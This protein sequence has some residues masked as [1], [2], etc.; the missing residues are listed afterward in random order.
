MKMITSYARV[1]NQLVSRSDN[2]SPQVC[3]V[4]GGKRFVESPYLI[5]HLFPYDK[6]HCCYLYDFSGQPSIPVSQL[7]ADASWNQIVFVPSLYVSTGSSNLRIV[8]V[9]DEFL[10]PF[11]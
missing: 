1:K 4:L 7:I 5:D 2:S 6:V 8:Q 10:K 9:F 11:V 3:V